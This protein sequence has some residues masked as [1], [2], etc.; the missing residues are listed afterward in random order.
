MNSKVGGERKIGYNWV[1][2]KGVLGKVIVDE[3][4][5]KDSWKE[6]MEKLMNKQKEFGA[7]MLAA[8]F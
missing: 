5:I 4:G 8:L 7:I 3:K 1:K 2:L 6:Y